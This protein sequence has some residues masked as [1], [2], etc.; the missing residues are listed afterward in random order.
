MASLSQII[1]QAKQ[2]IGNDMR[3]I[4]YGYKTGIS[5][6]VEG[7]TA[8]VVNSAR[9]AA[10]NAA[11]SVARALAG[12]VGAAVGSIVTGDAQGFGNAVG[13][14]PSALG[15]ALGSSI[16]KGGD[17]IRTGIHGSATSVLSSIGIDGST[18]L[19]APIFGGMFGG[20]TS[21]Q[22][23]PHGGATPG[24]ALG[25]VL[26]RPDPLLNF[27]W[28]TELPVII[29][30]GRAVGLPWY[31]VEESNVPFRNYDVRQVYREGRYKKYPGKYSVNSLRLG[32][33]LDS[34]GVALDYWLNW[35]SAI[36]QKFDRVNAE[37]KGGQ[38]GIPSE[39]KKDITTY[40]MDSTKRA[41]VKITFIECWPTN[42]EDLMLASASSDRL[43]ANVSLDVGDVLYEVQTMQQ[44]SLQSSPV[45]AAVA[46][47]L[48]RVNSAAL[49]KHQDVSNVAMMDPVGYQPAETFPV[50]V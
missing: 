11:R 38:F 15:G 8:N 17:A 48:G 7:A 41:V 21:S 47:V 36:L 40:I 27:T 25:G 24:N 30:S 16:M 44:S 2:Q 33:Y 20:T 1:S 32:V 28:Y 42:V 43:I 5:N 39:Y 19:K 29:A 4:G 46:G 3:G 22:S 37:T 26:A 31:Y 50:Q 23:S 49:S 13:G 35:D 14:I 45:G 18:I 34:S 10:T 12:Q 9:G 6:A